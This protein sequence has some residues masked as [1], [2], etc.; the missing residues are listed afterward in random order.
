MMERWLKPFA[1]IVAALVV[2]I[3]AYLF[4]AQNESDGNQ[5]RDR[6]DRV[7]NGDQVAMDVAFTR[8][9]TPYVS[10]G[11]VA[12]TVGYR[13]YRKPGTRAIQI[14]GKGLE[15]QIDA[16]SQKAYD[17]K[18]K[19][20]LPEPVVIQGESEFISPRSIEDLFGF[21][22]GIDPG[23]KTVTLRKNRVTNDRDPEE[24]NQVRPIVTNVPLPNIDQQKL[25]EYA[26]RF[27]GVDYEFGA[28]Y[29]VDGHFDCSSFT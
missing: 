7:N 16:A 18:R 8:N 22:T 11:R 3:G 2:V 28:E 10:L 23:R 26:A 29:P 14:G 19:F 12:E 21:R 9:G 25:L 20:S 27:K 6:G 17:G 5:A 1:G 15:V 24:R 13:V 4:L